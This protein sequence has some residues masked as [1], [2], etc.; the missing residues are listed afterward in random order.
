MVKSTVS[1]EPDE[2]E[3]N[4]FLIKPSGFRPNSLFVG[5]QKELSDMH[6]MLFDKKRRS[7]GTSAIL[8]QCLPGGGKSHLA[9]QYVYDHKDDYPGGIFW[10]RAKSKTELAAGFWDIARKAVLKDTANKEDIIS[11]EDP[12]QFIKIV[13]KW[14]NRRHD[15]LMV[16]DGIHFDDSEA[17]RKFIP[18]STN[19]SLI[20]TST[21]KSVSRSHHFMNPQI[22]RLPLLSAREAQQLLLLE[23]DKREPFSKDDLKHSMELVQA[24]GL[25]PVVI[26]AVAQRLKLTDEPLSK[27]AR[28]YA[29]EP[30]LSGLGAYK[31]VVDQLEKL[32]AREALNLIHIL[33]FYSQH[34]P[35]EMISLGLKALDVP[36]KASDPLTGR[37][38]N[39]TFRYLNMFALMDRNEPERSIHSSQ[40]SRSSRDMLA[41]NVDV[42]RL[43]GVVQGFFMDTLNA[44]ES[45]PLWLDR[46]VKVFCFSYNNAN[47]RITRKTHA[48][49]VEDYR[50][51]EIHGHRLQQHLMKYQKRY[52]M[53]TE[54]HRNLDQCLQAIQVEID[55]RTPE[56]SQTIA[57]GKPD[58][59]QTSIFD[60]TSSSSDT[61]PETPKLYDKY[62]PGMSPWGFDADQ[63]QLESP[64][65][66]THDMEYTK[67]KQDADAHAHAHR[68]LLHVPPSEDDGYDSDRE[69]STAMTLQPSQRTIHQE[70]PLSPDGPWVVVQPRRSKKSERLDLHR[71]VK[72]MEKDRYRDRAGSFRSL[73]AI[74]PRVSHD[75][76]HGYLQKTLPRDR[77]RGRISGQS[78]AEVALTHITHTS[79]PPP[80]EGGAI[81][82]QSLSVRR[83]YMLAGTASYASAVAGPTSIIGIPSPIRNATEPP[84]SSSESICG[85]AVASLQK[86][87]VEVV[88][89]AATP[90]QSYTPM[91]PYPPSPGLSYQNSYHLSDG[92]LSELVGHSALEHGNYFQQNNQEAAQLSG[93]AYPSKIYPRMTGP[94]PVESYT[95]LSTSP[96]KRGLPHDY[97]AWHSQG[98][99]ESAPSTTQVPDHGRDS[100]FAALSPPN[101]RPTTYYPGRP[102]LSFSSAPNQHDGGYTSQPMSRDPSGQTTHSDHSHH[103]GGAPSERRRGSR[104]PSVAE[105][106]PLPQLPVFSPRSRPTSYEVYERMT[107]HDLR[108]GSRRAEQER[109]PGYPVRKTPRLRYAGAATDEGMEGWNGGNEKYASPSS[110]NS[111]HLFANL[112][113]TNSLPPPRRHFNPTV[114]PFTPSLALAL[115]K[116]PS[117]TRAHSAST[118][119]HHSK[120]P[121][122]IPQPGA[123]HSYS[124]PQSNIAS[125][126]PSQ[127]SS[128]IQS[129][130]PSPKALQ[131]YNL[132]SS[133]QHHTSN[134]PHPSPSQSHPFALSRSFTNL[135]EFDPIT[136]L[137]GYAAPEM[138]RTGS[139]GVMVGNGKVIEFGD[140]PEKVDT[141]EARLRVER[142]WDERERSGQGRSGVVGLGIREVRR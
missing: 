106:E 110:V 121:F 142:S 134:L 12:Q 87:P 83:P 103:S 9:R 82:D 107:A 91:P 122:A 57:G 52:P 84:G 131:S 55:R 116:A 8:I 7:E 21:E 111:S 136:P 58:A 35:V 86:F 5:R 29:S 47:I 127:H 114:P 79:P 126:Y 99:S 16:L 46:A 62:P 30:R 70:T 15:W 78:S 13:K 32:D 68:G 138:G 135:E 129:G 133:N 49:L 65:S 22:I 125:A 113:G 31:A 108:D 119:P 109:A 60:R 132:N 42:I 85:S 115:P 14:L 74:D 141:R 45:L 75:H 54:T 39:N 92:A 93:D 11:P 104:R 105:T 10:L 95:V 59:F 4:Q 56:S 137:Q 98:Y 71:T 81:R 63:A 24:M 19:T 139:G 123:P 73:N 66:L 41:D 26:H 67:M 23:L 17:L 48:G 69:G 3:P 130:H 96:L 124:A 51:Y 64:S 112:T 33:C 120:Y 50:L 61:G 53:L 77:S 80:R 94:I 28:R 20:Y 40:S 27:F 118:S 101:P 43:H 38:L 76:A 1:I 117:S 140:F 37:S 34:I 36:V 89:Q 90:R 44:D 25:L 6:K 88:S 72:R 128:A 97:P 2:S 102:E 100:H 18:D